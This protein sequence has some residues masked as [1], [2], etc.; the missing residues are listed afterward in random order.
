MF[1]AVVEPRHGRGSMSEILFS[2]VLVLNRRVHLRI[3]LK[4]DMCALAII[5]ICTS[6]IVKCQTLCPCV[7]M[8]VFVARFS[9]FL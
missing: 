9:L 2:F 4:G 3:F 8:F 7:R 1:A 5:Q 6:I